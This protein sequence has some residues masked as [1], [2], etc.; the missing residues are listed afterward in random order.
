V[1]ERLA[2]HYGIPGVR[3]TQF[4]RVAL[5]DPNRWGLFGKGSLLTV[6]SYANRTSPVLRG[7]WV[8]EGILGT[9]P[10]DPPA[11]VPALVENQQGAAP[12]SVRQLLEQH[13]A[14]PSCASCH[15]AI[16][17][18][19]FALENFDAVGEWRDKDHGVPVEAA[20]QLADGARVD[21]PAA[22][23]DA[24]MKR[25]DQFLRTMTEKVLTYALGRS[26]TYAD[27][28]AVRGILRD[29]AR[30][31]HRFSALVM[32]VVKSPPFRMREVPRPEGVTA[33]R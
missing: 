2:R 16:D 6:T 30:E 28:P 20:G 18:P 3:G 10:P 15:R 24:V 4:R 5:A 29:T 22:L 31:N 19:G 7:R 26:V 11:D 8:L 14:N 32:A 21:G 23:R 17:P 27:M 12:R 1:N 25:P 33:T 13:R 9:P